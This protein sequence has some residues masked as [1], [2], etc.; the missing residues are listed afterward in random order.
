MGADHPIAWEH[1]FDGGRAWYT[2]GGHTT[3]S[4]AEPLFLE[5]LLGGI[6]YA[7]AGPKPVAPTLRTLSLTA[8]TAASWFVP[9]T[10]AA[11]CVAGPPCASSRER[12]P[13]DCDGRS[14]EGRR[15]DYPPSFQLGGGWPR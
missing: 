8:K 11:A 2:Q 4:Y 10:P 15:P 13:S 1:E 12:P 9:S 3:E 7:L 14:S 6:Q 5:H